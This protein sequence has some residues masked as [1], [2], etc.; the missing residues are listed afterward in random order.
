MRRQILRA[1]LAFAALWTATSPA[2]AV[3][4]C[5]PDATTLCFDQAPG[6]GRFSAR[7]DWS[8]TL[9]GGSSGAARALPLAPVGVTRGGLFWFFS[10][11]N[12]EV[13]V[14]VIDGC[15]SN[16]HAWVYTSAGT[17][18]GFTLTV[19][20]LLFPTHVWTFTNPD[21]NVAA[22]EADIEAFTC[23][24]SEPE[25]DEPWILTTRPGAFFTPT[26]ETPYYQVDIPVDADEVLY[27][28]VVEVEIDMNGFYPGEPGGK[29]NIFTIWR[30]DTFNRNL[31]GEAGIYGPDVNEVDVA[32][33]AD[34]NREVYVSRPHSLDP[35]GV[36]SFLYAY[37]LSNGTAKLNVYEGS[38]VGQ[39][40]VITM[41]IDTTADYPIRPV[42]NGFSVGFGSELGD[43][44]DGNQVP[45]IGWVY[46]NMKVYLERPLD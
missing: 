33:N 24:G 46:K 7:V 21:L 27:K 41:T 30:G 5:V 23:D 8:T 44:V 20:D 4:L 12:P 19:T 15:A 13:M 3:P 32:S 35:D 2:S 29:H 18:V 14:K 42:G 16:G 40:R 28:I 17:N 9:N 34:N 38:V 36:Y 39:N 25:P 45:T 26:V 11:D 1:T 22:P 31:F 10:A 37:D 6:D 43:G